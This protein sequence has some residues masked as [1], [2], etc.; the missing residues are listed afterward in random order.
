VVEDP[1]QARRQVIAFVALTLGPSFALE[2]LMIARGGITGSLRLLVLPVMWMPALTSFGLRL[3]FRSGF[4]DVGW[5][6]GSLRYLVIAWILP[7]A[8]AWTLGGGAL[9]KPDEAWL[10]TMT[11][12]RAFFAALGANGTLGVLVGSLFA[13]GE[14]LG[15]RGYLLERLFRAGIRRPLL[16][17]GVIWSIWHWPLILWG[18]YSTSAH[19][20]VSALQFLWSASAV[21]V[22]IGW[23]RLTSGSIWTAVLMHAAHNAFFQD[24]F[25]AFTRGGHSSRTSSGTPVCFP[26]SCIP[27]SPGGS[28]GPGGWLACHGRPV[29]R[30]PRAPLPLDRP[31]QLDFR[32]QWAR[33]S[34]SARIAAGWAAW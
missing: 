34:S 5:A 24:V 25:M 27:R 7:L 29:Q 33:R 1:A 32:I 30:R 8:L 16:W 19:P 23:L 28:G 26:R 21:A 6:A 15:W 18:G 4:R 9:E 11:P 13:A 20:W 17:S 31:S 3:A 14:E 2:R 10:R 12:T 22:I